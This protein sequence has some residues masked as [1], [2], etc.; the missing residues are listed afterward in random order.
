M[1]ADVDAW[2]VDVEAL[3]ELARGASSSLRFFGG[4]P[5]GP[6]SSALR[7]VETGCA[8]R[9]RAL[10]AIGF[11]IVARSEICRAATVACA[12]KASAEGPLGCAE[13]EAAG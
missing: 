12:N 4:E 7:L 11:W 3:L 2:L 8:V 1:R 10:L 9:S 6:G 13:G 5:P